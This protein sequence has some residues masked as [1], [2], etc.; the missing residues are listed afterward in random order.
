MRTFASVGTV[1]E[2]YL[3][4]LP[5]KDSCIVHVQL[6]IGR[7]PPDGLLMMPRQPMPGQEPI[8]I[9]RADSIGAQSGRQIG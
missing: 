7:R 9:G 1:K 5:P 4:Q 6:P 2:S 8:H 3:L